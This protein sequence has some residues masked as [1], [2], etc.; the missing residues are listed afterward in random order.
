MI[1]IRW[2]SLFDTKYIVRIRIRPENSVWERKTICICIRGIRSNP[3]RFHPVQLYSIHIKNLIPKDHS[4]STISSN[5]S[6][7]QRQ[8]MYCTDYETVQQTYK[9]FQNCTSHL[10]WPD[11]T[12]LFTEQYVQLCTCTCPRDPIYS[13]LIRRDTFRDRKHNN[14]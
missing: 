2:I 10:R 1:Q 14:W 7:F 9:P 3:I 12:I 8:Y 5:Q 11:M 13:V 6:C 4:S